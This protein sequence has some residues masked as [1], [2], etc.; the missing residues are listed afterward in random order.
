M[1]LQ[2]LPYREGPLLILITGRL[3]TQQVMD[4]QLYQD[5]LLALGLVP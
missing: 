2:E 5:Y 4:H 1:G 3:E